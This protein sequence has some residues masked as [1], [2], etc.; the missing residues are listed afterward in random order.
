MKV[1]STHQLYTVL[2]ETEEG[3]IPS[4]ERLRKSVYLGIITSSKNSSE[5]ESPND[6]LKKS[7]YNF[8]MR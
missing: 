1:A 2:G 3:P 7:V 5:A 8:I 6:L 4:N